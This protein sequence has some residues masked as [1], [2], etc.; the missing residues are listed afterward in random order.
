MLASFLTYRMMS[1]FI[2]LLLVIPTTIPCSVPWAQ[3]DGLLRTVSVGRAGVWG[4]RDGAIWYR[5]GTYGRPTSSGTGW[6]RIS[7]EGRG[8]V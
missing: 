8:T 1:I 3:T 4:A 5:E 6:K 7:G 2:F